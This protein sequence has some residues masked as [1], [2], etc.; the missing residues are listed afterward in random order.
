MKKML[1]ILN[2]V[3]LG[4]LLSF[5]I[6]EGFESETV[7]AEGWSVIYENENPPSG[8]II[9]H[10][11]NNPHSGERSFRFSSY[12]SGSPYGQYLISPEIV[13]EGPV[14]LSFWF[15]KHTS[16]SEVFSV[17][18]STTGDNVED[19]T[20][21]EDITD[22]SST[23]E[24]YT[25]LLD[26][27]V[28]YIAINYKSNFSYY[29]FIDDVEIF[30]PQNME[31][32]RS[33]TI[34]ASTDILT[35]GLENC[36]IL[37]VEVE[38]ENELNPLVVSDL[39]FNLEGTTSID[40]ISKAK[41]YYTALENSFS[42][43]NMFGSEID[44]ISDE[45]L[46]TGEQ[47]LQKGINY[48]WL[49][50][51][52]SES[53]VAGNKVDGSFLE[54][55]IGDNIYTPEVSSPEGDRTIMEAL[56]GEY[57]IGVDGD[58]PSFESAID[59]L[60]NLGVSNNVVFNIADGTYNEQFVVGEILG[61][62]ESKTITF[63]GNS[64]D[65]SLVKLSH[66]NSYSKNYIVKLDGADYISFENISFIAED[67]I[68]GRLVVITNGA[69]HNS[70]NN[71]KFLGI[72]SQLSDYDN[73][74][75]LI[76]ANG[77]DSD[78]LDNYNSFENNSFSFGSMAI[79]MGGVNAISPF[80]QG[81]RIVDN[82]FEGQFKKSIYLN[83]QEGME[84]SGNTIA[85]T[86]SYNNYYAIDGFHVN[87]GSNVSENI[88]NLSCENT[89]YGICLRPSSQEESGLRSLVSNNAVSIETD[90]LSYGIY[91]DKCKNLDVYHNSV[92]LTGNSESAM[93]LFVYRNTTDCDIK[94]NI[95]TN[96]GNGYALRVNN[97]ATEG[98]SYD[99]NNYFTTGENLAR[100]GSETATSLEMIQTLLSGN[101][102]SVSMDVSYLENLHVEDM[103]LKIAPRLDN[104]LKDIDGEVRS[105]PLT[106]IGS[107][108]YI[109]VIP[110]TIPPVILS[111]TGTE[112]E[113]GEDLNLILTFEEDEAISENPITATVSIDGG[114]ASELI[115]TSA[116]NKVSL[117]ESFS[118]KEAFIY[119]AT[120]ESQPLPVSGEVAITIT[121]LAGN[122]SDSTFTI[123][124]TGDINPPV[125]DIFD[126][127]SF[128]LPTESATIKAN[129]F[130]ESGIGEA[131]FFYSIEDEFIEVEMENVDSI[132][133]AVIPPQI[134]G[135]VALYYIEAT[136]G[137][138]QANI[139]VSDTLEVVWEDLSS[140]WFGPYN[141]VNNSGFGLTENGEI[142]PWELAM[143]Y[144][145]GVAS[146]NLKKISYMVNEGTV[147]SLS[148]SLL[149]VDSDGHITDTVLDSG[150]LTDSPV[151]GTEFNEV[152]INSEK[153]ISGLVALKISLLTGGFFGRDEN[154]TYN[155]SFVYF[156]D[157][158]VKLG[159]ETLNEYTGDWTLKV[160]VEGFNVVGNEEILPLTTSLEQNYP[161]PFN[162][163]TTINFTIAEAGKVSLDIFN[164]K[165]EVVRS[166][167]K[168]ELKVG[169]HSFTFNG[170]N[171]NS[172]VY[173]YRL[174]TPDK[175]ITKRM[176]MI[177]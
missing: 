133:T 65:N 29:L 84:I 70:F 109:E 140:G 145:L 88:I 151:I 97:N 173:F 57:T 102:N 155:N 79:N 136:D 80:E 98:N 104:V 27:D 129:I 58:F 60:N 25:S 161:N 134:I 59:A 11:D 72:E 48:F 38:T 111:L 126:A 93:N 131:K 18:T 35:Q 149:N 73:D 71:N 124:W 81:N 37:K 115:F 128:A 120:V 77:S 169:S 94:S 16:G 64:L 127:P 87:E 142:V 15:R 139:S 54:L 116:S 132:Y 177:K 6:S 17:G 47:S 105:T 21:G 43:D 103:E 114:E 89:S 106:F 137:S 62:S 83:Y 165:G 90:D 13:N 66:N 159:T 1:L 148:W 107:D 23:W 46:F 56:N 152:E 42:T 146:V 113:I 85:S 95:L 154:S 108:E 67:D 22:I 171:L 44:N 172:G 76:F 39:K 160:F 163:E 32:V 175:S 170:E 3:L 45:L 117:K 91:L 50:L 143:I 158:W 75:N 125:I 19:F 138:N 12:S 164:S 69:D 130:D 8:N 123:A 153:E 52:I 2:L 122:S 53:A 34:Q 20:W 157:E 7:P 112:G 166:F 167:S 82:S 150:V 36:E 176:V 14:N 31:Y 100:I 121:D 74:A 4:S 118:S 135:T 30:T 49:A 40:D 162:P 10:S 24:E 110:D 78:L 86:S 119:L 156:E 26:D 147:G 144:N 41:V 174:T 51:D 9:I 33:N 168:N 96:H 28:K 92:N 99:Y 55:K 141:P 61:V 101:E 63:K 68:Y 5:P